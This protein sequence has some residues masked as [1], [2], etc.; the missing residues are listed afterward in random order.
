MAKKEEIKNA[1]VT[2]QPL[3]LLFCKEVALF[4]N[5][6][7]T[8]KFPSCVEFLLQ[9]FEALFPKE[10]PNG[11]PPLRG[12]EHHIDLIPGAS[13]PNRP[14]Y[15]SNPQQTQEIQNQVAELVSKGWVRESLSPC[16]VPVILVPK[17]D[18]SWRMCTDCRAVNNITIKYRHPI[19]RLDDLL[20]ELFGACLFSKIDLKSGYHQI[21]IREGDEWKTAFKT[22]Y[23]LYEWMVM[24]FG[25]TNA[26]STFMRLMNH[27]LREFLGKFVVVYFDDILIY[28]KNLEEH[29][30]HLRAVLEVL[31][32]EHLFANL[33]KCVF[34]TDHVT[35]LGFV[36]SSKG[37]H[38]D[39]EKVRAI[40]DWPPPKNVSEVRSF[41]GL[42][43]FY[44]R[45]V[46]DFSTIAAPLNEIVKKNVVF[47]W[48]EKQEQAFAAL[49][50]KLTKAPI[51][52][53]PNFSKSFEIEC[54]ASNVGIGAVL[55]QEGHPI[56]Y[57]SEKLKGASLNYS[58]YDKELYALFRALQ[59]WQHYLLPKEFVIH[60]DHESLKHL[61]GQGKLNKRHAKW[62]EF[63]EQFPYV[64]KHKKGKAN[65]VADALS[66][67]YALLS[68]LETKVFGLEHIK[69]LYE[70]DTDFSSK[71][72]ACEHAA[73]NGYFRHNGYLFKEKRLCVPKCSIRTLLL[74]EAHEG[75]L[76][77]HFG[78][79]KTLELLQE[80]FYWPHMKIDVQKLCERCIVC[81]K[82]KSKVLPHGLYTPLPAPEFPWV[83]ISMDFVLG[84]PRTKN[85][86][87]SIFVVV[88]RFS[89]MAHFI[90][91]K[92][93]DDASHVA[94]LFFK[95]IVRIH[96][97]PRSIVSDRD[98]K[99]LS[100]F[101]RTLWGKIG[102]KLLFSTTCHPQTDGQTEV[103]NR[104]LST[105]LRSVLTRNLR[106]W[107]ECLPHVEFA[108]N[109]VVHSTTKMSPFEV[110]Y[111][112]NPL[113]PLDLLPMPNNSLLKHKNG[114]DKA[115]FVKK[116][117]EQVKLQIEKKNEGYAKHANKGRKKVIFEP[118]DWVWVHMRKERFPNQ[119]KSKLQPRGD[120]PFQV[121]ERINDNAY[122]LELPGE[123]DI[124]AT[125]NVADL[126]PF[127]VG[128]GDFNSWTNSFQEGGDDEGIIVH[129]TSASI[130]GLGGPMTRARA[131]KAKEA[132][133]QL[134][135]KVL[136]FKPTLGSMEGRMVMCIKPLEEGWGASL[137]AHFI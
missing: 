16:A 89:K 31:R 24:P 105:L 28:S 51:L 62:V 79:V 75:G 91:C 12:I 38:M 10:I 66:R 114:K 61:K 96:G 100:H 123:Y 81:K 56:A 84:L 133:N 107:E 90:A 46:K 49:K 64:I 32:K 104:T 115:E 23:G 126:A 118:G 54:D 122:K 17:K 25:L 52:A 21:R 85:G 22:K 29:C 41:H 71:F 135:A 39:E 27:V 68:T 43:S 8:Q 13:L 33:E 98:T 108:Y 78:V 101:W 4:T 48:G 1:I 111:G 37:I 77:G 136:E 15:R 58:T 132:L 44:R 57:F 53:L 137:A 7:N 45:F 74:K 130:Q 3:Y 40:K 60:S 26:P 65:V 109:R 110:V 131:K 11:L 113:T 119:R 106:M 94:D 103:V 6:P 86:K 93:V 124:S 116:M 92:K 120:G 112:F 73:I 50:E 5:T 121:L 134:V 34:C 69:S 88:D 9:E 83:D 59:T 128:D 67:R 18:G 20:D 30:G 19:P 14:A 76:M 82:A 117:H 95:E 42:A 63:L 55:M 127:D 36:V 87:D 47:K 97:V 129:D 80:H 70:S 35:F 99:F 102:T 2:K 125:F 72:F